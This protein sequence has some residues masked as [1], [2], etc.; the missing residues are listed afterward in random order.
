MTPDPVKYDVLSI[1]FNGDPLTPVSFKVPR[2]FCI[3]APWNE[4]YQ[5]ADLDGNAHAFNWR[6]ITSMV[7]LRDSKLEIP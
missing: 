2:G 7:V 6:T 4:M 1:Y 5:F 3:I